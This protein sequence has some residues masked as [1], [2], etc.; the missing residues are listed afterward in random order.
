LIARRTSI[1]IAHRLSTIR[2]ANNILVLDKG[3]V[4][5]FGPHEALMTIQNGK[6][7]ELYEK[8]FMTASAAV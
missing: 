7:R 2:K 6:Y 4:K 8:Q 5:E 1:I 3:E